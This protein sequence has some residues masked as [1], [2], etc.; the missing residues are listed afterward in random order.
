MHPDQDHA[1]GS[2]QQPPGWGTQACAVIVQMGHRATLRK[3]DG[4]AIPLGHLPSISSLLSAGQAL[5]AGGP[6]HRVRPT[7]SAV[8]HGLGTSPFRAPASACVHLPPG[9]DAH[10]PGLPAT[11]AAPS[12]CSS[13]TVRAGP[14]TP[15][16]EGKC[17]LWP[18]LLHPPNPSMVTPQACPS[19]SRVA[20]ACPTFTGIS[21]WGSQ[22]QGASGRPGRASDQVIPGGLEGS[23]SQTHC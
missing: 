16:Q 11:P 6:L 21:G 13:V 17:H 19:T 12:L 8:L 9:P 22:G 20:S 1:D 10:R 14:P 23:I 4:R 2:A 7:L 3:R 18:Q 5:G 15:R